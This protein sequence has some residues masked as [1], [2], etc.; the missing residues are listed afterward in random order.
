VPSAPGSNLLPPGE[1]QLFVEQFEKDMKFF[2]LFFLMMNRACPIKNLDLVWMEAEPAGRVGFRHLGIME[3]LSGPC[4][5]L[6]GARNENPHPAFC[7]VISDFGR[8]EADSCGVS[9]RAAAERTGRTGRS[10][11]YRCHFGL[12]DIAVPVIWSGAHIATLFSGQ[13]LREPPSKQGFVRIGKDVEGLPWVNRSELEKA[14][15][16]SDVVSEADIENTCA[17]LEA[18]AE[19]LANSWTRLAEAVKEKQRE[20]RERQLAAKEYAYLLLQGNAAP[21]SLRDLAR[22]LRITRRPNRV[23]LLVPEAEIDYATPSLSYDVGL[24]AVIQ[25]VEDLCERLPNVTASYLRG[26]GVCVFFSDREARNQ[27]AGEINAMRLA[28]RVLHAAEGA[29]DMRVRIGIGGARNGWHELA[30]SYREARSA[31]SSAAGPI[32][33]YAAPAKSVQELSGAADEICKALADRDVAGARSFVAAFP[34]QVRRRIGAGLPSQRVAFSTALDLMV[35]SAEKMGVD[36]DAIARLRDTQAD[37][38][39]LAA[40]GLELEDAFLRA[41]GNVLAE[42]AGLYAGRRQK[43]VERVCRMVERSVTGET[44]EAVTVPGL[45]AGAGVSVSHLSRL[46]HRETGQT[47]ECYIVARR[48]ELAKRL[49]LDPDRS[50]AQVAECCGFADPNYFSRVF[51]KLVSCSP[52]EYRQAPSRAVQISPV[53]S[54]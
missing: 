23:L 51:R 33:P 7:N 48:L 30:E 4:S 27:A 28:R 15:W 16:K 37:G 13:V 9:D 3:A 6:L 20:A 43:I 17:I 11:V 24:T 1:R 14:Y 22:R 53:K 31:L 5:R 47:L 49:L 46:F 54:K 25:A 42:T 39:S 2:Q 45:A 44:G 50:V 32:V 52:R 8:R 19:Y 29:S 21:Q 38:M 36:R 18:F 34:G 12:T 26:R 40:T 41:A 35:Y 10:E